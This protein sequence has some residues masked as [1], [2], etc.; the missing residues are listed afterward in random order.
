M[1]QNKQI[2]TS[3]TTIRNKADSLPNKQQNY[4]RQ[5]T[6][7]NTR[8]AYQAA[9]RQFE[10]R[11][12]LLPATEQAIAEYLTERASEVSPRTLSLHLT[13]LS[14]WHDYQN[15]PNPTQ[16]PHIQ[17]LLVG[18]YRQHGQPKRKAKALH[19]EHIEKMIAQCRIE[20]DLKSLRDSALIQ[21]AYFGAFRRSELVAITVD[22]LR[23]DS[24]GLL[25]LIPK[26][27]TDQT[28]EGQA[29]ALPY[30]NDNICPVTAMKRWLEA[31]G[32]TAG[33]VFRSVNRWNKLQEKALHP[34]SINSIIKS[35]ALLCEFDFI[36]QLS[37]HSLRRGFATSAACAGAEFTEIKRQGGWKNDNTV[38]EY[39]EDGQLFDKN[40]ANQLIKTSFTSNNES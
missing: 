37:S 22:H 8:R 35:L 3:N 40:A 16:S 13:A 34:D 10:A 17:K 20:N 11:G 15:L 25:I 4:L 12:G 39:I 31:S 38:R 14:H 32:I 19:P 21:T 26:S 1:M 36:N 28:G 27:K 33:P 23:F 2:K 6:A 7:K 30:G 24:R 5:A 18:I 29:K 9:V